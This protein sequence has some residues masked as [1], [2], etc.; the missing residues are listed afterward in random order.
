MRRSLTLIV[1]AFVIAAVGTAAGSAATAPT[2]PSKQ[3]LAQRI[4]K[5]PAAKYLTA[6]AHAAL[7]AIARGDHRVAPDSTGI[8][9]S[10][11]DR[12]SHGGGP[13]GPALTNVPVSNPQ[14][15]SHQVDQ[16]TQ[17]ETSGAVAGSNVAV[18]FNDSQTTLLFFT[19]GT[20]LSGLAHSS[21]GGQTF[22]D[23][24]VLPPG[25][26]LVT[27]ATPGWPATARAPSTTQP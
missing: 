10:Q 18:G 8:Q 4:L 6:T 26:G 22:T 13:G 21:D 25:P 17:S 11:G 9:A 2:A 27:S 7:E 12:G 20:N 24:G 23:D 5:T 19:A 1:A 14:E 16:T 3:E 15:D